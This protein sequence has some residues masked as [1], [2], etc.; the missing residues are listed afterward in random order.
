MFNFAQARTNMVDGQIHTAGVVNPALLQAF[1]T[2][3]RESFVPENRRNIAYCDENIHLG[4]GRYLVEPI[5]YSK[6]LQAAD[7]KPDDVVLNIGGGT[8]YSS[9]ILSTMV[10][11]VVALDNNEEFVK[12]SQTVLD[13][14]DICNVVF[15]KGD[16][17]KGSPKHAPYSLIIIN[18]SV[19]DIPEELLA[20]LSPEGRLIAIVKKP[21]EVLG[22]VVIMHK[23]NSKDLG[24]TGF[25]SYTLFSAGCPYLEGFEPRSNFV[26]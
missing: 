16:H 17:R 22:N 25:S 15:L 19:V 24:E 5:A 2:I 10:S 13:G 23:N 1:Q 4:H 3:P 9:A 8:G 18:G 14:L 26:F 20:Q 11:T 12:K 21:D 6:M 7:L